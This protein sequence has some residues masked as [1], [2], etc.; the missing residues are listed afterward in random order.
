MN[1]PYDMVI[2]VT[3]FNKNAILAEKSDSLEFGQWPR[4]AQVLYYIDTAFLVLPENVIVAYSVRKNDPDGPTYSDV[5]V[6]F[7][8]IPSLERWRKTPFSA[9]NK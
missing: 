4:N 3:P 6:L 8:T 9:D 1:T 2:Q 7:V 5:I